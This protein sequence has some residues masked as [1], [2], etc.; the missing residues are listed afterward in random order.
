M[1]FLSAFAKI[2]GYD[3]LRTVLKPFVEQICSLP[4]DCSFE[5][6]PSKAPDQD[7]ERNQETVSVATRA[8]LEIIC[9]SVPIV[10]P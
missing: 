5:L 10:P 9:S 1:L 7:L 8:F 6:D 2:H 3:Y 4:D